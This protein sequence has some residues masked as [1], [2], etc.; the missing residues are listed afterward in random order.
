LELPKRLLDT[1]ITDMSERN[2][3]DQAHAAPATNSKGRT[4]PI[5]IGTAGV[6]IVAGIMFQWMR[7]GTAQSQT[8]ASAAAPSPSSLVYAR[9]NGESI[10]YDEVAKDAVERYGA[11]ILDN[12]INRTIIQ[13]ACDEHGVTVTPA[14]VQQEVIEI[15]SKFNLPLETWYQM[16]ASERGITPEQ[17]HRDVIWPMLALKKL[18]GTEVTVTEEDMYNAFERD[19]GPR[20]RA[21]L[22]LVE[23][24]SRQANEIWSKCVASPDTFD[25]IA[26]EFSADPNTRPLG[27]LIPPIRRNGGD[28]RIEEAAFAM[29]PGQIS[30]LIQVEGVVD[31]YVILKCEGFTEPI[32]ND[33]REVWDELLAQITEEKVQ[34][35]VAVTF[36]KLRESAEIHNLLTQTSSEGSPYASVRRPSDVEQAGS[37][38]L[39]GTPDAVPAGSSAL[40]TQ[41]TP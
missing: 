6:I 5:L 10:Y 4:V 30:E 41:P 1:E 20:V 11:E 17:Y 22:I 2:H 8:D 33:I 37:A 15:A 9:V 35:S 3:S 7:P 14:E 21:R 26:R 29:Q 32:V 24:N 38:T 39:S 40:F 23:G 27:G 12:L 18:A 16:L 28:P 34:E 36:E 19:Y 13:Q 31:R 25:A